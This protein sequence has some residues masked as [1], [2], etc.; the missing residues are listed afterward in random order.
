MELTTRELAFLKM[1]GEPP[2][3]P[4]LMPIAERDALPAPDK[5]GLIWRKSV[6]W[7]A[8]D[9]GEAVLNGSNVIPFPRKPLR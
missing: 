9:Q 1:I 8:S 7:M 5:L 6:S 4:Q 2:H 3:M